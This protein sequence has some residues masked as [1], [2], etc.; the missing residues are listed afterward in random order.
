[1]VWGKTTQRLVMVGVLAAGIAAVLVLTVSG[2]I[3]TETAGEGIDLQNIQQDIVYREV[4]GK[5]LRLDI[6]VPKNGRGP[7]PAIVFVHGGT[8]RSGIRDDL[9][10]AVSAAAR[11]GF[12]AATVEYRLTDEKHPRMPCAAR[13]CF[14]APYQDLRYAVSWL[15]A[16]ADEFDIDPERI[17]AYGKGA[18]GHLALLL[19]LVPEGHE[20]DEG[21][22]VEGYSGR[23][24]AVVNAN[25]NPDLAGTL[26]LKEMPESRV[27][28]RLPQYME[29]LIGA[30]L[31][32]KPF[33]YRQASPVNYVD[34]A[35]VPVLSIF[36]RDSTW[37]PVEMA[38]EFDLR[39][40]QA[41]ASHTL[42]VRSNVGHLKDLLW[43]AEE[44]YPVWSFFGEYLK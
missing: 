7:F 25:G 30:P 18:G 34:E 14:P 17:G 38:E 3:G 13:Y 5:P 40:R 10:Y 37:A 2:S 19:G 1:M 29:R 21:S 22:T 44:N 31:E 12:V 16:N 32:Q 43:N 24:R 6:A 8:W 36:G 26:R 9:W 28:D 27:S 4:D 42:I 15:R 35:A 39:M 41:G 23:V 20:L 11:R 33:R